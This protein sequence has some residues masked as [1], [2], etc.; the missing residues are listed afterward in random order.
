MPQ[1]KKWTYWYSLALLIIV[2]AIVVISELGLHPRM[3]WVITLVL[4]AAFAVIAGQGGTG[5]W[6]GIVIDDQNKVSLSRL[7]MLIWTIIV[8][9]GFL[10]SALFNMDVPNL[11]NPLDIT[12]PEQLL[13]LMGISTTSLVGS[14]LLKSGKKAKGEIH[15]NDSAKDAHWKDIF[16]GEEKGHEA[17]IDLAKVQMFFFTLVVVLAYAVI[18][19]SELSG[20]TAISTLPELDGSIVGLLG[21]SHAGYLTSK[22]MPKGKGNGGNG[23]DAKDDSA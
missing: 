17:S 8:A 23:G 13:W 18:M 20:S 6:L 9:S 5:H 19:G 7:Q 1:Q 2:V 10:S 16:M 21:I 4:L 14:P 3:T 22:G 15:D 12:I 11:A